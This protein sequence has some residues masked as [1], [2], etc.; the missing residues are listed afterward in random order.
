MIITTKRKKQQVTA[1]SLKNSEQKQSLLLKRLTIVILIICAIMLIGAIV[2]F[3]KNL[4]GTV[5]L[6]ALFVLCGLIWL[7]IKK[8]WKKSESSISDNHI[9]AED[10]VQQFNQVQNIN[11]D[12]QQ[13]STKEKQV[14]VPKNSPST[15]TNYFDS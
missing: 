9:Q 4:L 7:W 12:D 11:N 15:H 10:F 5:I 6:I 3:S 13:V 14:E 2:I 8:L 1:E